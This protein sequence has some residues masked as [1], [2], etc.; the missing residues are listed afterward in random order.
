MHA[1]RSLQFLDLEDNV[2]LNLALTLSIP[3]QLKVSNFTIHNIM[4]FERK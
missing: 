4:I 3:E 1:K 2:S